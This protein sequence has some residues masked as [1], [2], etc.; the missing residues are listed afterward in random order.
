MGAYKNQCQNVYL[1]CLNSKKVNSVNTPLMQIVDYIYK[2]Q[3]KKVLSP[4]NT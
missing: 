2:A 3:K 1:G 4:E